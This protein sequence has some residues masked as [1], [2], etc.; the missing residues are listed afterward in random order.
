VTLYTRTGDCGET[1]LVGGTRI[2][3]AAKRIVACGDIDELN[4]MLGLALAVGLDAEL[5][6][7]VSELQRGLFSLGARLSDPRF[8]VTA[9]LEKTTLDETNVQKLELW[10]DQLDKS[11]PTLK[12]FIFPG[13]RIGGSTLHLARAVCR[14]AER[15]IV[16]LG[17]DV[18]PA[19]ILRY[20][21]RMSDLLFVMGRVENARHGVKENEW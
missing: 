13:G 7:M 1:G 10:I 14:R 19:E 2:S 11:L 15:N 3:K 12:K 8:Q 17:S 4:A 6:G 20:V 5:V 9:G 18:V 16:A 21:N